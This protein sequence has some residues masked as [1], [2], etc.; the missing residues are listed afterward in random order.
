MFVK[1]II[2]D[3][4]GIDFFT[5]AVAKKLI[6]NEEGMLKNYKERNFLKK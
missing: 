1:M 3:A 4:K 6:D 5:N 2:K